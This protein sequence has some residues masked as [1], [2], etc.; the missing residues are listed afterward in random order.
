MEQKKP[1][2]SKTI[3]MNA[4]M[5]VMGIIASFGLAHGLNEWMQSNASLIMTGVGIVGIVLRFVTKDKIQ[6]TD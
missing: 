6:L 1:Y 2:L 3:W 4:I 5:S